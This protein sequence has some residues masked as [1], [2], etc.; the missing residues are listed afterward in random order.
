MFLDQT[1]F[2]SFIVPFSL[3]CWLLIDNGF[4]LCVFHILHIKCEDLLIVCFYFS[5]LWAVP[6]AVFFAVYGELIL[7]CYSLL[8]FF[9]LPLQLFVSVY[10]S[11]ASSTEVLALLPIS[12]TFHYKQQGCCDC[13]L[14]PRLF[15]FPCL[16][17]C[18]AFALNLPSLTLQIS[19]IMFWV[20]CSMD[21][22]FCTF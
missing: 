2:Y 13:S 4:I 16:C 17:S 6:A 5:H 14:T 20:Y 18:W 1:T 11:V 19:E 21:Q 22:N 15:F 12:W 3:L 9:N 7:G 10:S 8:S